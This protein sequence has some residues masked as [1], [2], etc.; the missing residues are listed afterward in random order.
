MKINLC[1]VN[2]Q[3]YLIVVMDINNYNIL[4]SKRKKIKYSIRFIVNKM[5]LRYT[6]TD[7][8]IGKLGDD[9]ILLTDEYNQEVHLDFPLK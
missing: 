3:K 6:I 7:Y 5:V 9:N 2:N 1:Y 8:G 4:N